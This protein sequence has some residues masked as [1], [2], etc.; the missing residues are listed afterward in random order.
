LEISLCCRFYTSAVQ[1]IRGVFHLDIYWFRV[2]RV[3]FC[4]FWS[5][6]AEGVYGVGDK[7][8]G[9]TT[10]ADVQTLLE[11]VLNMSLRSACSTDEAF[12]W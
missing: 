8:S 9:V 2:I 3:L 7:G 12:F 10:T 4:V 6:K 5:L 11:A 1:L